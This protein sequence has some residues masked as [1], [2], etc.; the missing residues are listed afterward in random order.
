MS[1]NRTPHGGQA[2]GA[3]QDFTFE[4][5]GTPPDGQMLVNGEWVPVWGISTDDPLLYRDETAEDVTPGD[6]GY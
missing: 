3:G 1:D 4:P 5:Q 6:D 2:Q